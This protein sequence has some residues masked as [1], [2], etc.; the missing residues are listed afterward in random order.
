LLTKAGR[1]GIL[2]GSVLAQIAVYI[3]IMSLSA[4]G[5]DWLIS[6]SFGRLVETLVPL[7]LLIT[8]ERL[9]SF[10]SLRPQ[11]ARALC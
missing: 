11:A 6:A 7:I 4:L 8:V 3:V 5:V 10:Q 1:S 2:L 9:G